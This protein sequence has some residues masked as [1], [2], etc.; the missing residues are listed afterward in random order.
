MIVLTIYVIILT[1]IFFIVYFDDYQPPPKKMHKLVMPYRQKT[2][3]QKVIKWVSSKLYYSKIV[4]KHYA[5]FFTPVNYYNKK[6]LW[7][8]LKTNELPVPEFIDNHF[9]WTIDGYK[10]I[11]D[12]DNK[13]FLSEDSSDSILIYNLVIGE[14]D[15]KHYYD[16]LDKLLESIEKYYYGIPKP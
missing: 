14:K 11:K 16:I 7:K 12:Y 2:T 8:W 9:V 6:A 1:L 5:Q 3:L 4:K 10:L 13:W 15:K